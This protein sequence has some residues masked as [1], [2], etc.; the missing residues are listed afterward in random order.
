M[1]GYELSTQHNSQQCMT[2]EF[3]VDEALFRNIANKKSSATGPRQATLQQ[4][5][6]VETDMDVWPYNRFFRGNVNSTEPIVWDREAGFRSIQPFIQ[7][8]MPPGTVPMS[9]YI[10]SVTKGMYCFQPPCSTIFPCNV[11][12]VGSIMPQKCVNI[13]P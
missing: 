8:A 3:P 11:N 2:R 6:L 12:V 7:N 13:S 10:P 4:A 5:R 9:P 1:S